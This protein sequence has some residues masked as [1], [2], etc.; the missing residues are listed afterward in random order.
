MPTKPSWVT[1]TAEQQQ[2][3]AQC[4]K[5]GEWR[6][7]ARAQLPS[8][9]PQPF[10]DK[11]DSAFVM[12]DLTSTGG[13]YLA[14]SAHRI[15]Y[16]DHAVDI[17]PLGL[18]VHSTG[19][20]S[21]AVF[22]HHGDWEGR[23]ETPQPRF[24]EELVKSRT[25]DYFLTNPPEGSLQGTLDELPKGHRGAFEALIREIRARIDGRKP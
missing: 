7:V 22:L 21:S 1:L 12:A 3:L 4:V 20:S 5:P 14:Y 25:G 9:F 11:I 8:I 19:P 6:L 23:T 16:K 2:E 15:D 24:W 10:R 17:E 18:I 13:T